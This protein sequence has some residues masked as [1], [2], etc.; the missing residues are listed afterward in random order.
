MKYVARIGLPIV[1][2]L[3]ALSVSSSFAGDTYKNLG[4]AE[5]TSSSGLYGE[6]F[7]RRIANGK[8]HVSMRVS[9]LS[10][11]TQPVWRAYE[12]D[13]CSSVGTLGAEG[14]F[15]VR[16]NGTALVVLPEVPGISV[17]S[18]SP[19]FYAVRVYESSA[20]AQLACGRVVDLPDE[21]GG[22]AHWW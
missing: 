10:P 7:I 4:R 9:G 14:V 22:S 8:S 20:G 19:N 3:M 18:P 2:L 5:L 15:N 6:V 12:G 21:P 11:N 1:A 13:M 17:G 16:P